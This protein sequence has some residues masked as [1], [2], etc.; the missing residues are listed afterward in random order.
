MKNKQT[1][2]NQSSSKTGANNSI[3]QNDSKASQNRT[4][5]TIKK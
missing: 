2:A 1:P 4:K 5:F 3:K